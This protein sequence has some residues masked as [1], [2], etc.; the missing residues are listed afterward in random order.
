M[1]QT[2]IDYTPTA[3]NCQSN[4]FTMAIT[5]PKNNA[6]LAA[7]TVVIVPM[8]PPITDTTIKNRMPRNAPYS[9]EPVILHIVYR[10]VVCM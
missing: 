7:S 2:Q 3:Q 8:I 6:L 4:N 1:S 5:E 9:S 10:R